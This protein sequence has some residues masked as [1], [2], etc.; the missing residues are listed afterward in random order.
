MET[1]SEL[2]LPGW[3]RPARQEGGGTGQTPSV[4]AGGLLRTCT[5]CSE[6]GSRL[7]AGSPTSAGE[8]C[9]SLC[10][11]GG[12]RPPPPLPASLGPAAAPQVWKA[13]TQRLP[14]SQPSSACTPRTCWLCP[15]HRPGQRPLPPRPSVTLAA[16]SARGDLSLRWFRALRV[17]GPDS[18]C[19]FFKSRPLC[20]CP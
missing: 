10:L 14:V 16:Y 5:P 8:A 17:S 12:R 13:P 6:S 3:T 11:S 4:Q 7:D 18:F 2:C 1:R 20:I 9:P 19:L 15:W